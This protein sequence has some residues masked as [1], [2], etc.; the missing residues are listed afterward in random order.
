MKA[1]IFKV[2]SKYTK[3]IPVC[4]CGRVNRTRESDPGSKVQVKDYVEFKER[5]GSAPERLPTLEQNGEW[6]EMMAKSQSGMAYRAWRHI[7]PYGGTEYLSTT[8]FEHCTVEEMC[9]FFN[10]DDTRASW[11]R[12]L[13]R[14]RVLE[15]AGGVYLCASIH[16]RVLYGAF[17]ISICVI[18]HFPPP[19]L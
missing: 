14:H 7:L 2:V 3:Y 17:M 10:C 4:D 1:F 5:V 15:R 12:L 16:H 13:Y 19:V 11:D 8:T 6:T 18:F 9:D